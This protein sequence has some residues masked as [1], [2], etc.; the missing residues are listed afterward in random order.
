MVNILAY[1]F[2]KK[3]DAVVYMRVVNLVWGIDFPGSE[4]SGRETFGFSADL[5][6]RWC[7]VQG[8]F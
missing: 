1:Q 6:C 7:G 4:V 2:V 3:I 5:Y 8:L